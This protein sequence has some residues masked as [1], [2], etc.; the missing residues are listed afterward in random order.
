MQQ[1][2]TVSQL[3]T[4]SLVSFDDHKQLTSQTYCKL[5]NSQSCTADTAAVSEN[6]LC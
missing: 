6:N 1:S 4:S 2:I 3:H 5:V